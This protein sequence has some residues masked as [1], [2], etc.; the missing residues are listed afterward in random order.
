MT[1]LE[2]EGLYSDTRLEQEILGPGVRLLQGHAKASL[3][4]LPDSLLAEVDGLMTLRM[5]VP[6]EQ[7]ARFPK[8]K[9]VVRMGVGY[10]RVDRAACAAR[11]ILVANVPDYGTMEVA[12]FAVLL[13]LSLRRGL[14]L[15]HETQRGPDPAPWAVMQSPLHRR[16]EVQRFGI[17]GLGRI[18][19]AAALRA[20]AFGYDVVFF[21][22]QQPNG[23]D[24]A[25]GIRRARSLDELLAQSDVLSIHCP[26]TRNTRGMIGERELRL[27]PR[28]AVVVNTAR[29][30]IMDLDALERCLRDGHI[31]GAGLDVIPEEPPRD[32]IPSLLRAYRDRE[33]WLTG[34]L[35]VTPHIAFHTPEAWDDIRRKGVETMRDVLVEG[36]RTNVIPPE[37]D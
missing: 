12:E 29:G 21:D 27:L 17:L 33:P 20:R 9:V 15:Y 7:I 2:P 18:G 6:A 13:A 32:P 35:V 36:R 4:E 19:S 22:P 16:Q 28:N 3:A 34:R 25:L 1:V 14:I 30:P 10:D 31:A 37:S 5:A 23:W 24:R 26:L 11:G 8:L